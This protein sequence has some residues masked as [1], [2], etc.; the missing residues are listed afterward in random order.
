MCD[1]HHVVV[2][3]IDLPLNDLPLLFISGSLQLHPKREVPMLKNRPQ[4][5]HSLILQII[6][7]RTDEHAVFL[8]GH[9]NN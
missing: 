5:C 6:K 3:H 2:G 9:P 8:V 1:D 7:R 4:D